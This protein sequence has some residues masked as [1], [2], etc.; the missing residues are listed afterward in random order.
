MAIVLFY[1]WCLQELSIKD[2]SDVHH[3]KSVRTL[4]SL[5]LIS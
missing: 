2:V 4:T 1:I 3:T 5:N